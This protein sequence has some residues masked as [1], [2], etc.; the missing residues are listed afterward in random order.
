MRRSLVLCV[1]LGAVA[2]VV[3]AASAWSRPAGGA[4]LQ[5]RDGT[6]VKTRD[7][8]CVYLVDPDDAVVDGRERLAPPLRRARV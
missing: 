3:F 8:E 7:N 4:W 6:R 1:V 2:T 5:V